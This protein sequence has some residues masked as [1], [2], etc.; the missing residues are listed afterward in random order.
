MMQWG[1][2]YAVFVL[3]RP[4]EPSHYWNSNTP[5]WAGSEILM[6]QTWHKREARPS[7][8]VREDHA[9]GSSPFWFCLHLPLHSEQTPS[10]HFPQACLTSFKVLSFKFATSHVIRKKVIGPHISGLRMRQCVWISAGL[11][12]ANPPLTW[13]PFP[14][15]LKRIRNMVFVSGLS[16]PWCYPKPGLCIKS[17]QIG[18]YVESLFLCHLTPLQV[19]S[20]LVS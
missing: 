9:T 6:C 15:R 4:F 17:H 1:S 7:L 12:M 20:F 8:S 5:I 10:F 18:F 14:C 19:F 3:H 13:V 16:L 2:K 11:Q